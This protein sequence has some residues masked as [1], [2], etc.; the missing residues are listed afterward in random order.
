LQVK[1]P[2]WFFNRDF[3]LSPSLANVVEAYKTYAATISAFLSGKSKDNANV[4][5]QVDRMYE[6]EK[7]LGLVKPFLF[8]NI[9]E[10]Q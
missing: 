2:S 8:D 9:F 6:M 5:N 7:E 4:R 10:F 1:Q 3:Y